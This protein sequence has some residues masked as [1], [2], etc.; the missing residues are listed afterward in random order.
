VQNE[1][2]DRGSLLDHEYR[3]TVH[4]LKHGAKHRSFKCN[5]HELEEWYQAKRGLPRDTMKHLVGSKTWSGRP[6]SSNGCGKHC[7]CHHCMPQGG[8]VAQLWYSTG[9]QPGKQREL[10]ELHEEHA[11][12]RKK[13][14][15]A[16][17]PSSSVGVKSQP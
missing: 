1:L 14:K 10:V 7:S 11:A 2:A 6:K 9:K 5:R 4:E 12:L 17:T 13:L 8:S 3:R 16:P 15:V